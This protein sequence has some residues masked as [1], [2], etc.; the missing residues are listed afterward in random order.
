MKISTGTHVERF[1][2][3]SRVED[4]DQHSGTWLERLVFNHRAWL[5]LICGVISLVLGF[6]ATKLEV[7]ASFERMIPQSH[8]YIK[9][10]LDNKANL[11]GLGNSIRILASNTK[12]EIFDAE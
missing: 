12:G 2:V 11:R 6:H 8:P 1:P 7:N 9:N 4:F 10:Y 5:V 3:V